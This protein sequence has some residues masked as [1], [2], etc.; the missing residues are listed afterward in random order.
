MGRA[1]TVLVITLALAA[2]S[3]TKPWQREILAKPQMSLDA[4]PPRAAL[5]SHLHGVR[6]GAVGGGGGGGGGCGCN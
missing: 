3:T 1:I 6:E 2:C 4:D 5:E